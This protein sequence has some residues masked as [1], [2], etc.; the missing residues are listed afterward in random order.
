M[1][2]LISAAKVD[3]PFEKPMYLAGS[4]KR[5]CRALDYHQLWLSVAAVESEGWGSGE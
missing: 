2:E 5:A 3:S 4:I 1:I